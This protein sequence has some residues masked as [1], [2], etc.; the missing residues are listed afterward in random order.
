MGRAAW[1]VAVAFLGTAACRPL[2]E[3]LPDTLVGVWRT[4]APSH[5]DRYLE[6][7]PDFVTFGTSGYT[8]D[9]RSLERV[10]S[11]PAEPSEQGRRVTLVYRSA[12]GE[13]AELRVVHDP[14]PP[15]TL[16]FS[17]RPQLWTREASAAGS[18]RFPKEE[19]GR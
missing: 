14:G 12:D 13:R 4:S 18:S 10:H 3:G 2:D 5:A 19:A 15:P 8:M 17:N 9:V 11:E 6:I 7:E 1:A 16:R